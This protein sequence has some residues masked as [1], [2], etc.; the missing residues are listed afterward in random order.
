MSTPFNDDAL[1]SLRIA[2]SGEIS[3]L[4]EASAGPVAPE[5]LNVLDAEGLPQNP[6]EIWS[7]DAF[8]RVEAA[9]RSGDAAISVE[10]LTLYLGKYLVEQAGGSW[11]VM[12]ISPEGWPST[13]I[14]FG[15]YND[16]LSSFTP[17]YSWARHVVD[18]DRWAPLSTL[19]STHPPSAT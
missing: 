17:V 3:E 11:G 19:L 7:V 12:K 5:I 9:V 1:N 2:L 18:D 14:L 13:R 4:E 8:A 15:V 10:A 16:R 6:D